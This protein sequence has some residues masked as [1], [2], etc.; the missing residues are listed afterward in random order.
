MDIIGGGGGKWQLSIPVVI[1]MSRR[2][3]VHMQADS[4]NFQ[5]FF[6]CDPTHIDTLLLSQHISSI[7][8]VPLRRYLEY[9]ALKRD[10]NINGYW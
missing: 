8:F 3:H 10:I 2:K 7:S 5:C 4:K 1:V 9:L 6:S